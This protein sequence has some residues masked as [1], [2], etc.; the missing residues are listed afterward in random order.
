MISALEKGDE[1]IVASGILGTIKDIKG[2]FIVV[3]VSNQFDLKLQKSAVASKLPKG[4]LKSID[5]Q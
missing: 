2:N 3:T 1:V 5:N 4:T